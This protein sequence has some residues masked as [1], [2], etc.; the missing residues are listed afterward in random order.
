MKIVDRLKHAWNSFAA[1]EARRPTP[2][3]LG[4]SSSTRP[5]RPYFRI[6]SEKTILESIYTRIA[7]DAAGVRLEHCL[8]N[9]Q[10]QFVKTY[11]SGLNNCL[12]IE[13]N[14]DQAGRHFRQDVISTLC[15][16]GTA[17]I[18]PVE[19]TLDP[20]VTGSWDVLSMRV[21]TIVDWYAEHVLVSVYNQRRARQQQILLPKSMVAIV[22]NPFYGVMNQPNS[23]LQRLVHK[24]SLLDHVD[25]VASSGKLD[26]I[27]QLP[28]TI[29]TEAR[30]AQA[31]TR[32]KEIEAQLKDSTYGIA[33]ADGTEHITQLNRSVENNL[34]TQVQY[35]KEE[36]FAELGL[37]PEIMNGSADGVAMANYYNRTIEPIMDAVSEA[38]A[39]TFLTKTAR[40]QGQT[41]TYFIPPFKLLPISE[42]A[43]V[44]D[45]LSRNQIVTPNEVRPILG[46]R[47]SPE[48][49]ANQLLNSN[50]PI[51]KQVS[52][53]TE[54]SGPTGP[55]QVPPTRERTP[56]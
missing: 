12:T 20:F 29:R 15:H 37:T 19:T 55:E 56:L 34:L 18:I 52:T 16:E 5:D 21:G 1:D 3:G 36:L 41:I 2:Y 25:Q 53:V 8:L 13:A 26:I 9:E 47:P 46:L 17:A 28:Y 40:A 38:I 51:D 33:Y 54:T 14:I 24:L 32:R 11:R 43:S 49:Q 50:M 27:I 48:P 30:K 22:E 44:V 31:E 10:G 7:V 45:V 35:L 42:F 4:P 6:N 39:R 23:T